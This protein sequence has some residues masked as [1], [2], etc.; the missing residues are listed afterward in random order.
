MSSKFLGKCKKGFH[1]NFR[2]SWKFLEGETQKFIGWTRPFFLL[3]PFISG[4]FCVNIHGEGAW[5]NY[6]KYFENHKSYV[7]EFLHCQYSNVPGSYLGHKVFC[8]FEQIFAC[9]KVISKNG[10]LWQVKHLPNFNPPSSPL[11]Y[12]GVIRVK[13]FVLKH[14][15][16]L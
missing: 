5:C 15:V 12:S 3:T 6:F 16:F 10:L 1:R 13:M 8:L 4:F 14:W 7:D 2:R 9:E 11:S